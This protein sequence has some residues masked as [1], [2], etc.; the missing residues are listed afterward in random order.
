MRNG[1]WKISKKSRKRIPYVLRRASEQAQIFPGMRESL[2]NRC[3]DH[4]HDPR[5]FPIFVPIVVPIVVGE[6]EKTKIETTI[7][8]KIKID[9]ARDKGPASRGSQKQV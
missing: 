5:R 4:C 2:I 8:T 3:P 1:Q 9:K 6:N 7:R